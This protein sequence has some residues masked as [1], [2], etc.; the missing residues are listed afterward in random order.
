MV[1]A[2]H[3]RGEYLLDLRGVMSKC[4]LG[5]TTVAALVKAGE[6]PQPVTIAKKAVRWRGS[7]VDGWIRE[8]FTW[9]RTA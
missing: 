5:K 6:F 1:S 3:V 8:R 4:A 7:D 2:D 9:S